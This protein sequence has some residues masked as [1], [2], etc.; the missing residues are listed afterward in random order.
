VETMKKI[1]VL[2]LLILAAA[3]L[4]ACG[5]PKTS[6][7][8]ADNSTQSDAS[9]G[10]ETTSALHT[11]A[12]PEGGYTIALVNCSLSE[13]WRV[14]MVAEFEQR[15]NQL[16][17]AGVIREYY[18]TNA[19]SDASK[20]V[21]D[22]EDMIAKGVDGILLAAVNP[23][24]LNSAIQKAV[25]AGIVVVNFNSLT[26]S[27][28]IAAKIYQSD[29]E[30]GQICAQFLVDQLGGEGNIL[31]LNGIAG[32]S[33]S[34]D[35]WNGAHDVL[36][37]YPKLKI[38]GEAYGEWDYEKGKSATESL[39]AAVPQVD[40]VWSQGGA[41]TQ[42]AIDAF[43][44]A[45]RPLVPMSGEAGNGYFRTWLKYMGVDQFESI[46]PCY[47]TTISV[48][49]LET[50]IRAL[51]GEKVAFDE[52]LPIETYY[53]EDVRRLYRPDLPDSFWCDTQ[54]TDDNLHRLFDSI[55]S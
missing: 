20:Q 38:V 31:V 21:S 41:M 4:A 30:F 26:S 43:V 50:L 45:G 44:E 55:D 27:S 14:Q 12:R 32:N 3:F 33:V 5:L 11:K 35:R 37:E 53:S 46:A 7:T 10:G 22:M 36:K 28:A 51:N 16:K 54:L 48:T 24:A 52:Q 2:L 39:L 8:Q 6:G 40:G 18:E 15:A 34:D 13:T 42:G 9:S 23:T 29:Y 19:D 1:R 47:T 17:A 49:A 25:D